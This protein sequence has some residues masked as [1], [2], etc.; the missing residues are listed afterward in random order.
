MAQR[1]GPPWPFA[2]GLASNPHRLPLREGFELAPGPAEG[3]EVDRTIDAGAPTAAVILPD[4]PL[5]PPEPRR[6]DDAARPERLAQE[7]ALKVGGV[8]HHVGIEN[9]ATAEVLLQHAEECGNLRNEV[10][11]LGTGAAG[12]NVLQV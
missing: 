7:V 6:Y 4:Q 2:P 5:V 8:E 1:C 9:W 11:D 12:A 10:G 3:I